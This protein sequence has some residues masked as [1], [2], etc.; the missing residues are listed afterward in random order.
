MKG[1]TQRC[2]MVALGYVTTWLSFYQAELCHV[3]EDLPC[4]CVPLC[5]DLTRHVW[6]I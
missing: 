3:S 4:T 2:K 5:K 1:D 6:S